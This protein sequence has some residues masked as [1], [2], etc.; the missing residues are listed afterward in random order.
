MP[1]FVGVDVAKETRWV[2]ALDQD[3]RVVLDRAVQ[4]DQA[5]LDALAAELRGLGPELQ[6]AL[7]V[8]GS[9]ASFLEAVLLAE[10]FTLVHIPGIAVN[11]A[12]HGFAGGERK[13]DPRDART[14]AEL[15]RTRTGLRP[16]NRDD[17]TT[18]AIRLKIARRRDLVQDQ[19][20]RLSRLRQLLASIHPSLER[21]LDVTTKGPLVLLSRYVAPGEIRKAG[22]RRIVA[23]LKKTPQLRDP[24]GLAGRAL[25]TATMQ[26][27]VVR[28]EAV[29]ADMVRE[30]AT[31][32]L[33]ARARIARL[34]RELEALLRN[35]PDG[36]LIQSVPGMGA[37]LTA[38]FVAAVG[39]IARFR[40]ADAMAAAAGLAPVLRQSGKSRA[41][42]RAFGGD[43]A[44]KRVFFQSAFCAVTTRDPIST[45]FYARKRREGKRHNQAIIALARRRVT[46]LW[47]ML[48]HRKPF[49]PIPHAA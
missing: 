30:L 5:A 17:E 28:G 31:E 38:E 24:E 19:T 22:R 1:I 33:A 29:V 27:T 44:L 43:K 20:R 48:R 12:G 47:S 49:E 46:V 10:G 15:A 45:A 23:H 16:I 18:I 3:A 32:A 39:D 41:L 36:A 8:T 2:C 40:S 21:D 9:I 14:I 35:H 26:T 11:R 25:A 7:D 4:N 42:R 34:D 6:I 37:I 13:S